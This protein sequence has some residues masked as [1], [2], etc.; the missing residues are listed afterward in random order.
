VLDDGARVRGHPDELT[1]RET[2]VCSKVLVTSFLEPRE[3]SKRD[4]V[5][6]FLLRWNVELD[7]RNIKETLGMGR[8]SCKTPEMCKKELGV[9]ML[10][11]NLMRSL[12]AEAAVQAGVLPRQLSF[13]YTVQF[14]YLGVNG[15]SFRTQPRTL[16]LCSD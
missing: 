3:I 8:L 1:I 13:K 16:S 2:K 9:Y 10:S 5:K 4:L 14:G 7:I 11:Y 12:M 15:S 6:L